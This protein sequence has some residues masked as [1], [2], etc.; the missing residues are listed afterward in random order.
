LFL[1]MKTLWEK[2]GD[3]MTGRKGFAMTKTFFVTCH[4][5]EVVTTDEAISSVF[6]RELLNDIVS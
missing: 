4:C 6:H 2:I 1:N 3:P 5:E